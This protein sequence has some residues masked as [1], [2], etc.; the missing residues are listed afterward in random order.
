MPKRKPQINFQVQPCMK[1]LYDEAK[2]SGHWVARFCA[3]GFLLM[4]EEPR[5]RIRAINRLRAWEAQFADADP[6]KIRVF[7]QGAEDAMQAAIPGN[8]P[9]RKAPRSRKKAKRG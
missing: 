5:L 1:N 9:A 4:I 6:E 7:V 3:A 8:P 2:A